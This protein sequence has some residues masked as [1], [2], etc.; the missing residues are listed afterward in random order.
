MRRIGKTMLIGGLALTLPV[1]ALAA[2]IPQ[3]PVFNY[4]PPPTEEPA[5]WYL[6]LDFG[7]K[8][9]A[10]PDASF[11]L[12]AL[13]YNVPGSG[14]FLNESISNTGV[15]GFGIGWDPEGIFRTDLTLD[16]EWP[17]HF[18]GELICPAPCTADP[19]P[20]YSFEMADISA[21]TL[22]LNGYIDFNFHGGPLTP[23]IGGGVGVSR[24]TT[25][26]VAFFNPDGS[27]GNWTGATTW[28]FA[29]QLTAGVAYELA[30]NVL[31]DANY[32]Y[33]HLGDAMAMTSLGGGTPI[34]YENINAH[35]VRVGLRY[36]AW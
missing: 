22:L 32:R 5:A 31:I 3:P 17:G 8:I 33:V 18:E 26:N 15:V 30:P 23:Y 21:L 16:Y 35:E 34:L 19:D 7:Y 4:P 14:E 11:N 13:G 9:Y 29:W 25:S 20:E 24:L 1:G 10:Q 2:D 28:N 27:S 12:P 6:R 36:Y